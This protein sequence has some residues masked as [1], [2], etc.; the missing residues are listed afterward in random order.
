MES[1][2]KVQTRQYNVFQGAWF[3]R[4]Y[5]LLGSIIAF[6][7]NSGKQ[8]RL[9]LIISLAA[10]ILQLIF[11]YITPLQMIRGVWRDEKPQKIN[12]VCSDFLCYDTVSSKNPG[13]FKV[14]S[15][16]ENADSLTVGFRYWIVFIA[17]GLALV[18]GR[19]SYGYRWSGG[20]AAVS[21]WEVIAVWRES[22]QLS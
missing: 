10:L 19:H 22:S 8:L 13:N 1:L 16:S 6:L 3:S 11:A 20:G 5:G 21:G 14:D 4:N 15:S 9:N 12:C 7:R 17:I 18:W 2:V